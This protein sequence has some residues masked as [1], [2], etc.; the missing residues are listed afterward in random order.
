MMTSF[1]GPGRRDQPVVRTTK[2]G[3]LGRGKLQALRF[4]RM[5]FNEFLQDFRE[6]LSANKQS[7][8][9]ISRSTRA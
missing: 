4:N 6:G 7:P 1:S 5:L 2:F 9:T 8:T 3:N